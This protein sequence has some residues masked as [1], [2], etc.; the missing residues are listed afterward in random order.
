MILPYARGKKIII[1][2]DGADVANNKYIEEVRRKY[3]IKY[4]DELKIGYIGHLYPGKGGEIILKLAEKLPN[5][6]FHVFGGNRKDI[7]KP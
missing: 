7:I 6:N 1:A 5:T 2:N 4:K 3:F